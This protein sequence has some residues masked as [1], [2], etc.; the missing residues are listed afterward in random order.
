MTN[1]L[2]QVA[3]GF[4]EFRPETQQEFFA[5]QLARKLNDVK[6]ARNYAELIQRFSEDLLLRCYRNCI[7]QGTQN[8]AERFRV[9]LRRLTRED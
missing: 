4:R 8:L 3:R 6:S 5:L 1:I 9:E 7:D 2:D